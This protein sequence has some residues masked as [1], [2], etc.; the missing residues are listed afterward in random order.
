MK[1]RFSNVATLV[2]TERVKLH[3]SQTDLSIA[4]GYKNGQ[5]ISNMERGLC[6]LPLSKT[7]K[8]CNALRIPGDVLREALVND[9]LDHIS[10]FLPGGR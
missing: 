10:N 2:Q 3:I 1:K 9:Y 6:S 8:L 4:L 7:A 5:F